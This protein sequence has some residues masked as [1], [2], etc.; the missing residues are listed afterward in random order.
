MTHSPAANDAAGA[1]DDPTADDVAMP[2][3]DR[4]V[5]RM[6]SEDWLATIL[7]LVLLGLALL[8]VITKGMVP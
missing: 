8:G 5:R 1:L 2:A 6:A 4:A 3:P 7:G